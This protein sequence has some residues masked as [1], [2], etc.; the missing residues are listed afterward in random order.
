MD[1]GQGGGDDDD[2][3]TVY[4][5][6]IEREETLKKISMTDVL[7]QALEDRQALACSA[8]GLKKISEAMKKLSARIDNAVDEHVTNS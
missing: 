3:L 4:I 5:V 1:F 6:D 8:Y 2:P 7:E